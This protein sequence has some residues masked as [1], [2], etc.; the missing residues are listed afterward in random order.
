[1]KTFEEAIGQEQVSMGQ[2]ELPSEVE[3]L[4]RNVEFFI[5]RLNRLTKL[6]ALLREKYRKKLE[7]LHDEFNRT[8]R[9]QGELKSLAK[10]V[11]KNKERRSILKKEIADLGKYKKVIRQTVK[12][13]AGY[14]KSSNEQIEVIKEERRVL[15]Q[16]VRDLMQMLELAGQAEL[17]EKELNIVCQRVFATKG[18]LEEHETDLR[19]RTIDLLFESYIPPKNRNLGW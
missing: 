7:A 9:Y 5:E 1:M 8:D 15:Y 12:Q 4:R 11:K 2:R 14:E 17:S 6:E 19:K 13:V 10:R 18:L 3:E 16:R